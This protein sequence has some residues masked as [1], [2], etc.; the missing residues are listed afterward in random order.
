M[1]TILKIT[2]FFIMALLLILMIWGQFYKNDHKLLVLMGK[3]GSGKTTLSA[4]FAIEHLRKKLPVFS[5]N[6]LYGCYKLDKN[7]C[8]RNDFPDDSLLIFDEGMIEFDNRKFSTF[9]DALRD[10]FI[11]QRHDRISVIILC[12]DFLID[13]KIRSLT[14]AIYV[15]VNYFNV[16][17]IAKKVHKGIALATDSEGQ[18]SIGESYTWEFPTS[19]L[20]CF[21]P[22][23]VRFF[24]SFRT[25]PKPKVP[26]I[27][28]EFENEEELKRLTQFRYWAFKVA[29]VVLHFFKMELITSWVTDKIYWM[30]NI[31]PCCPGF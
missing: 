1:L 22:R 23:W 17:T 7:W 25:E 30:H 13:K 16:L 4:R 27:R 31:N 9:S 2:F 8:G 3:K 24:D 10:F 12:Q 15:C 14:D 20:F 11:M 21:I 26:M 18:G 19:W 6:P 28:Y 5:D 29:G